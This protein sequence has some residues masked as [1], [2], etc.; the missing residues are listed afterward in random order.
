MFLLENLFDYCSTKF[1]IYLNYLL[2]KV[3]FVEKVL[4][5]LLVGID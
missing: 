2:Y 3:L 4:P 5:I 1:N